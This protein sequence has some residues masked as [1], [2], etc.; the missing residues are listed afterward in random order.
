MPRR[1]KK[2][3]GKRRNG[4]GRRR[5]GGV[6][7]SQAGISQNM[8]SNQP[9]LRQLMPP[10]P[11]PVV[12][13]L[14][15]EEE[16]GPV[17]SD[18]TVN[19]QIMQLNN[20]GKLSR[21]SPIVAT[22]S[23]HRYDQFVFTWVPLVPVTESGQV[24]M[25]FSPMQVDADAIGSIGRITQ[26]DGSMTSKVSDKFSIVSYNQTPEYRENNKF[27]QSVS[28]TLVWGVTGLA[29]ATVNG[30]TQ[31]GKIVLKYLIKCLCA[32]FKT[33]SPTATTVTGLRSAAALNDVAMQVDSTAG[34]YLTMVDSVPADVAMPQGTV[35]CGKLGIVPVGMT[36]TDSLGQ[37]LPNRMRVFVRVAQS[38]LDAG[39][40][41]SLG[42]TPI[43]G[44]ISTSPF[45][46]EAGHV[47]V[48]A[49]AVLTLPLTD[50]YTY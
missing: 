18:E 14:V 29:A 44:E 43:V 9:M 27:Y 34:G 24:V 37:P 10:L 15:G 40:I 3:N 11:T 33:I 17:Y 48:T 12:K 25:G 7:E 30:H 21:V 16:V 6:A 5:G 4:N 41:V 49:N 50:T 35:L 36:L 28:G 46:H 31:I 8:W 23:R 19:A 26:M 13:N 1:V 39:V 38:D 47:T 45:F 32:I 2:R 22:Y 42:D 20:L